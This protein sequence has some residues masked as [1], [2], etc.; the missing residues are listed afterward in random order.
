MYSGP[1]EGSPQIQ[2]RSEPVIPP[3]IMASSAIGVQLGVFGFLPT[4]HAKTN[5]KQMRRTQSLHAMRHFTYVY[6][7]AQTTVDATDLYTLEISGR[8]R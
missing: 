6:L 5:A 2:G 1:T 4:T 8:C 7:H 3:R